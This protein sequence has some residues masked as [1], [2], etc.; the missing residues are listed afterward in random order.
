MNSTNITLSCKDFGHFDVVVVGGGCTGVFAAV[1][2]ARKGLKVAIVEKS[3]CFGG[4]ATNGLVNIWHSLYDIYNKEQI[5]GGLTQELAET[6]INRGY[7]NLEGTVS[8]Y[9]S[10]D[11][12]ALKMIL[13]ELVINSGIKVFFHTFYHSLVTREGGI[14]AVIVANKDGLG[15]IGADFFIDATGDGDLCR[16][17]GL[18]SYVDSAIQPPSPCCFLDKNIRSDLG[19]LIRLHGAEFG[20]EDDWG[21]GGTIPGLEDINF[22]ADFHIF[23]KMCNHADQLTEAEIEGR[24]KI[25]ALGEL[26]KKY[27]DPG[28]AIVA[29]SSHIGIRETVH[30]KTRFQ[31]T[32]LELLTGKSYEDTVMRGTYR[33]DIHHQNDNGITFKYLSGKQVTYYGKGNQTVTRNWMEDMGITCTP[34]PYYQVPFRIL[35]Q[36]KIRNL[37]PVG[38]MLNADRG[39]FGA[40]RVMVNLNQLGEAAGTAAYC[41]LDEGKPIQDICGKRVQKELQ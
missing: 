26:L 6:L 32:E 5:I 4:V 2:A 29:L 34:A 41:C 19:E 31:A 15:R 30:Y 35:V 24:K 40:L 12:N 17:C 16:D 3:N 7:G 27:D 38:R 37:I 36:E 14:E 10:F 18:E 33:V 20:L 9:I 23:G 11:P 22:R 25:Y 21:W 8:R 1:R 39:S 13:D 28:H